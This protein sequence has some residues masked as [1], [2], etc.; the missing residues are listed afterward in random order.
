MKVVKL[1]ECCNSISDGDHFPP[2]K[3]KYG[4]PFI[5]IS[6]INGNNELDLSNTMFV[7][8]TYYNS[9]S[10]VKKVQLGDI[11]Y[12][13]VGSFGKPVYMDSKIRVVFQRH[14]AILK[15]SGNVNGRFLYY[16]LLNPTFYK[17]M[18]KLAIGC[19]QRTITLDTLRNIQIALPSL[20]YQG[21]IVN[22][23]ARLDNKIRINNKINDNL[24]A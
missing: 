3:A 9:L 1:K 22:V 2:P 8:E 10:D 12:S 17:L 7:P 21:R 13:V 23:L 6:N 18:D 16:V 11:L 24:A 19:S 20:D 15:P 4:V 5:T 14:I